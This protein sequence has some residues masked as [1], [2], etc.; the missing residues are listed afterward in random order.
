LT[1]SMNDRSA[2]AAGFRF[3]RAM[4]EKGTLKPSWI[5]SKQMLALHQRRVKPCITRIAT[6]T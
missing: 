2:E 6:T 5:P 1:K 3:L 4:I